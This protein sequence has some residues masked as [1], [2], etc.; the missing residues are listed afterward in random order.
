MTTKLII[1]RMNVIKINNIFPNQESTKDYNAT[2]IKSQIVFI[3]WNTTNYCFNACSQYLKREWNMTKVTLG[4][5][6]A[7]LTTA[8]HKL[9]HR[10]YWQKNLA[11]YENLRY[12][13]CFPLLGGFV[14]VWP[15]HNLTLMILFQMSPCGTL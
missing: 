11:W 3:Q 10:I 8:S 5:F 1:K 12:A 4:Q 6:R 7:A 2:N 13:D 15:L 9:Y 14:F